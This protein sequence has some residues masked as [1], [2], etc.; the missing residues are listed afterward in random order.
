MGSQQILESKQDSSHA[1]AGI[2]SVCCFDPR[3]LEYSMPIDHKACPLFGLFYDRKDVHYQ[4]SK[5]R[6]D[7]FIRKEIVNGRFR[8]P[9]SAVAPSV[10]LQEL[11]LR[12]GNGQP[13]IS[14]QT[15]V[16]DR[17]GGR[18]KLVIPDPSS[19]PFHVTDSL[20]RRLEDAAEKFGVTSSKRGRH[21]SVLEECS[22][23]TLCRTME[24]VGGRDRQLLDP[25][26]GLTLVRMRTKRLAAASAVAV[27]ADSADA[28]GTDSAGADLADAFYL[29]NTTDDRIIVPPF[30]PLFTSTRG[31]FQNMMHLEDNNLQDGMVAWPWRLGFVWQ[32]LNFDAFHIPRFSQRV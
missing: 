26:Q 1:V 25:I 3:L 7:H 28:A 27:G 15:C 4:V 32:S 24:R 30:H 18:N 16:V 8:E 22:F 10:E 20:K 29:H 17:S 12:V 2:F 6:R 13:K 11:R 14:L 31:K 21:V 5:T 23:Q 19:L 9:G